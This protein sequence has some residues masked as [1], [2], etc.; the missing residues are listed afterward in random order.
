MASYKDPG[1][2]ERVAL[3]Q[4]AKEK[5]LEKLRNKP[6]PDPALVA[7]RQAARE[8]KEAAQAEKRAAK[9][10]EREQAKAEAIALAEQA[11]RDAE[12]NAKQA[13]LDAEANAQQVEETEAEKKLKRD[14]RY[15]ARKKRK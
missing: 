9:Q 7:E 11:E 8:A 4:K 3:A 14:A 6:A 5:A 13:V 10:A 2:Q 1:F 12:A 15:A